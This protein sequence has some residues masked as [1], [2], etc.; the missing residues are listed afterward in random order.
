MCDLTS[1]HHTCKFLAQN[2]RRRMMV[3]I[4]PMPHYSDMDTPELKNKLNR[5]GV[6]PLPK[7]QMVVK[8]KEIHQYTHQLT[9]SDSEDEEP[10]TACSAQVKPLLI[11]PILCS[12]SNQFKEPRPPTASPGKHNTKVVEEE[13]EEPL[14]ASQGSN[15]SSNAASEESERSNPELIMSSDRDSDSDGGVSAS[16]SA[17]RLQDR[18]LAVRGFILSHP[19]LYGRILQYQPLVLSQLQEQL[20]AAGIRLGVAKLVDYLDSQCITFTTAKPG[21]P[22]AGRGRKTRT[23]VKTGTSAGAS[24]KK[25]HF[26]R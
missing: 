25:A 24:R 10:S 4:T 23:R 13:G 3:P 17:S 11:R 16:Q 20:K 8:L 19:E 6:R 1:H 26:N 15:T 14:S 22:A 2:K 5:Y 18:L 12:T 7:R 9:S 21:Q